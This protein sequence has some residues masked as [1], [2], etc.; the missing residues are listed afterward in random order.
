MISI[1]NTLTKK[2][3]TFVPRDQSNVTMYVCGPTVYD[4]AHIG[5]ARSV[6]VYDILFRLLKL[7]YKKVTYVRNITDIDDKII[8]VAQKSNSSIESITSHYTKAFH[9]DMKNINCLEPTYEPKATDNIGLMIKLIQNLLDKNHAYIANKHIYFDTYSYPEYG[10]LSGKKI[11]HLIHG[12][13]VEI[14]DN[15]RH[16][17]DFILWKPASA[18]DYEL[19]S[20]WQSPWGDGRPGWHIECSAMANGYLGKNFDIHGGGVDLQFPHHENEIAQ[21]RCAFP[22]SIFAK[23]WMHNG[24]LT[25]NKEKMSK[26]LSNIIKIK[27]LLNQG[28]KGEVIRYA[29]LKTHYRKPLD[30]TDRTIIEST[31]ALNKFNRLLHNIDV[32]IKDDDTEVAVEFIDALKRDLNVPEALAILHETANKIKKTH[33]RTDK[34]RLIKSLLKS[35]NFIGLLH[36]NYKVWFNI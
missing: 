36:S 14:S 34:L 22:E 2:E 18:V 4:S 35:A 9:M 30:W 33:N 27:D 11:S 10:T 20:F 31:G 16:Q 28:I 15:K 32:E 13:R 26:S 1:Y 6:I 29:L 25:V 23:Y 24:F 8:N 7:C 3:E 19:S 5:N 12:S 17:G 21:S